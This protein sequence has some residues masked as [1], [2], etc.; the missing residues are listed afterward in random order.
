MNLH[1][2]RVSGGG[3]MSG[4]LR[5]HHVSSVSRKPQKTIYNQQNGQLDLA[6]KICKWAFSCWKVF[7][8]EKRRFL[9]LIPSLRSLQVGR[10]YMFIWAQ[11]IFD[12]LAPGTFGARA[13]CFCLVCGKGRQNRILLCVVRAH[14]LKSLYAETD[15]RVK[16]AA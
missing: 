8:P 7:N 5:F 15:R 6:Q 14:F 11:H 1:F 2:G 3:S 9:M 16:R 13:G 12:H 4:F 10:N